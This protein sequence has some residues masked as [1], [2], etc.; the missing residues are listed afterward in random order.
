[1]PERPRY[2][3]TGRPLGR[4]VDGVG[5]WYAAAL[6]HHVDEIRKEIGSMRLRAARLDKRFRGPALDSW[7]AAMSSAADIL[8]GTAAELRR[9]EPAP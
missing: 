5:Y 8:A 3:A 1:M 2:D 4:G 9:E 7:L 6:E